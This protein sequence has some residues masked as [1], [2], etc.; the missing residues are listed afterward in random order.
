MVTLDE[1]WQHGPSELIRY[2]LMH[3]HGESDSDRRI[4]FLLLDVGVET[5]FKTYLLLPDTV[6]GATT[7]YFDRKAAAEG[8][9]HG[10]VR[11]VES[12]A[13]SKL[14]AFNL[15]HVE[16]Y[17]DLRNKL[18]HQGNGITVPAAQVGGYAQLATDL[19]RALLD[20][21]LVDELRRPE[22]EARLL[23]ERKAEAERQEQELLTQKEA[24]DAARDRLETLAAEAAESIMPV[25][26][27]R[28]FERRFQEIVYECRRKERVGERYNFD[29]QISALVNSYPGHRPITLE[30]VSEDLTELRLRVTVAR[31]IEDGAVGIS[32]PNWAGIYNLSESYPSMESQPNLTYGEN[33]EVIGATF[34]Q[35]AQV[36]ESGRRWETELNEICAIVRGWLDRPR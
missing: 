8:N 2:A 4:A 21:D 11:G 22:I 25:L 27:L 16:F 24:I 10:L 7:K 17:H 3:L 33:G 31:L 18:Y 12:A 35:H 15:A 36:I 9:F 29:E 28:S 34:L 6:T 13:R 26:A 5:L 19:L 30:R 32:N 20:V 1:P 23:A 14:A